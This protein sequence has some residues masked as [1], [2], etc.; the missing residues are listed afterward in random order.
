MSNSCA[1]A[2]TRGV[3][4]SLVLLACGLLIEPEARAAGADADDANAAAPATEAR[5][6][7]TEGSLAPIVVT[8]QRLNEARLGIETQTGAS[9]Y[10][11]DNQAI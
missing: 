5:A 10:T 4:G 7:S 9:T 1:A 11:I 3:A 8:A 6:S 2:A